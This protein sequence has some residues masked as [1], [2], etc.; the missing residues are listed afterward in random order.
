MQIKVIFFSIIIML[1]LHYS[2]AQRFNPFDMTPEEWERHQKKQKITEKECDRLLDRLVVAIEQDNRGLVS[3][4]FTTIENYLELDQIRTLHKEFLLIVSY[5]D[6]FPKNSAYKHYMS[7]P[8]I[9]HLTRNPDLWK[10][11]IVKSVIGNQVDCIDAFIHDF[12]NEDIF[13]WYVIENHIY[14]ND[15]FIKKYR[16]ILK[17]PNK[18]L[19]R[20]ENYMAEKI[21]VHLRRI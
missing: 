12:N 6:K 1:T 9:S 21:E 13:F 7:F 4:I 10:N 15:D 17:N 5:N 14:G 19:M 20:L 3:E 11:F 8:L 16:E 18:A 2:V